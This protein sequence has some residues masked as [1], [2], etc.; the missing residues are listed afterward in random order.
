MAFYN[1]N[2]GRVEMHLVSRISQK[3]RFGDRMITFQER[4]TIHTESS[5]KYSIEDFHILARDSN[6]TI[7]KWWSDSKKLFCVYYLEIAK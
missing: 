1:E 4:E 6:L 3:V 7:K 2:Y 5:Y